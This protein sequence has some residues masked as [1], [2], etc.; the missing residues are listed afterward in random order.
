M[1]KKLYIDGCSLTYGQGLPKHQT[2]SYLFQKKGGYEV[3]DN[4][5]P[6]KSNIS[7]AT[8]VYKHHCDFD[9][10]VIG[11]TFS[12]R[13]GIKYRGQDIDFFAGFHG[14][15]RN[16]NPHTLDLAFINVYKFFYTV[17]ES[18][19]CDDLS[20]FIVD[21]TLSLLNSQ[22]KEIKA[23]SWEKRSTLNEVHYPYISHTQR[24]DD[25]HLNALGTEELYN[26]L[27]SR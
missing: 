26:F 11:W 21:G 25:G 16:F 1:V 13:F 12:N 14:N 17:F 6:G 23:F 3:F 18:P 7:I 2:L 4:S 22:H 15:P 20:D 9:V 24:L 19:F 5:R 10:F 8:D 27:Q